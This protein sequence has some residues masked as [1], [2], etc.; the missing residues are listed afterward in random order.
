M[1]DLTACYFN[2]D[3]WVMSYIIDEFEVLYFNQTYT[4]CVSDI[5]EHIL[6][7]QHAKCDCQLWK[8]F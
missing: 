1:L 4:D 8:I 7:Y 2:S 6:V 5:N 3:F